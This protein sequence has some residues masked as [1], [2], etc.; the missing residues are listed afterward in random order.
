MAKENVKGQPLESYLI[1]PTQRLWYGFYILLLAFC[2]ISPSKFSSVINFLIL[3]CSKYPLLLQAL[4][5]N[6]TAGTTEY[7]ELEQVLDQIKAAVLGVNEKKRH[8]ETLQIVEQLKSQIIGDV[9]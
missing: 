1:K 9:V 2:C 7:K 8:V 4:L 5:S 6:T 3:Y